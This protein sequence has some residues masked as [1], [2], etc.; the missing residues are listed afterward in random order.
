LHEIT[1][2]HLAAV[3]ESKRIQTTRCSVELDQKIGTLEPGKVADL[4]ILDGD[5]LANIS[6]LENTRVF[7][8][9][10]GIVVDKRQ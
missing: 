7:V 4:V 3:W 9:G 5:P 8:L 2:W 6:D 1:S 10:R